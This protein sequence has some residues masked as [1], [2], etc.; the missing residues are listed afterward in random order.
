MA[1]RREIAEEAGL[2]H[3]EIDPDFR[4]V[5]HYLY[6][7]GRTLVNKDVVYFLARARSARVQISWE[8]VAFRWAT[9]EEAISLIYYEN[10]RETLQDAH[11]HLQTHHQQRQAFNKTGTEGGGT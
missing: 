4:H 11:Q 3:I 7:R 8:H 5:V 10:A 2:R 9:L 1:A 6:R